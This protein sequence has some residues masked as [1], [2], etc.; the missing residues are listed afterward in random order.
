MAAESSQ[1]PAFKSAIER[2]LT[3]H[4][5]SPGAPILHGMEG[6]WLKPHRRLLSFARVAK[7]CL[8]DQPVIQALKRA[9]SSLI[10]DPLFIDPYPEHPALR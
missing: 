5:L 8:S 10:R 6:R 4:Q 7:G 2:L 9:Q 3:L 1:G